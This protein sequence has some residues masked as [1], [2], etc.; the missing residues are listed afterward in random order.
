MR[1]CFRLA[2]VALTVIVAG[3]PSSAQVR[4][5][6]APEEPAPE[7]APEA[8][9]AV[10]PAPALVPEDSAAP[11]GPACTSTAECVTGQRCRGPR[12]CL[13]PW[14][15]GEASD[16]TGERIA[17]CDCDGA[18]FHA[19]AGCPGR[20]Y[21]HVGACEALGP[22]ASS[23]EL[24]VHAYDEPPTTEDRT[25]ASNA[26]CRRGEQCFGPPGCGMAWR[27]ERLRGC[28]GPRGE[29]CGCDGQTFR[30]SLQCPGRPIARRGACEDVAVA[31]ASPP[32]LSTRPDPSA[33]RAEERSASSASEDAVAVP[34]PETDASGRAAQSVVQAAVAP[35]TTPAVERVCASHR[36]CRRGEVCSGPAG[37][38]TT[39]TC[40][41]PP[42]RCN[43]DTQVF[44]DCERNTFRASMNCPG[45]PHAHRGSCELDRMLELSGAVL[46]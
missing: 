3:C 26:D 30:G 1:A 40:Q 32:A 39:W 34:G 23:E 41:R 15:C 25:C 18:T 37:C 43:P 6:P 42:E 31:A 17:Y 10:E 44:C 38:G 24:G 35:A 33:P 14:A 19:P 5:E 22:L 29:L 46:R 16:C 27:C 4:D 11:E 21:L 20:T 7:P 9:L 2:L 13:S 8:P 45:R 12:G 28:G 36:D